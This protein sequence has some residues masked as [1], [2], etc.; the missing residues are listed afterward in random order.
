MEWSE[1]ALQTLTSQGLS[2]FNQK[3]YLPKVF[4]FL[5]LEEVMIKNYF[6]FWYCQDPYLNQWDK[7]GGLNKW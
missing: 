2:F 5:R 6:H 7:K 1:L 4:C 3:F